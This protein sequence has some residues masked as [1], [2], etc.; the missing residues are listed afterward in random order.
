M[1]MKKTIVVL[2]VVLVAV[3]LTAA[4]PAP[5]K[6]TGT[7]RYSR[8]SVC[9]LPDYIALPVMQNVYLRGF[10]FPTQGQYQGCRI[11]AVG[12]FDITSSTARG[13]KVFN[14]SKAVIVCPSFSSS[15]DPTLNS[16]P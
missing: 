5:T 12:Y 8:A 16:M 10:G 15:N 3:L 9:M 4:I 7:L 1:E 11:D 2:L 13:C 14:V 6:L